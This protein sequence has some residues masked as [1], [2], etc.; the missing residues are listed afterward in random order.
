MIVLSAFD[1]MSC[2]QIALKELGYKPKKY[3][4]SEIDKFAIKQTQYNFQNTIQLG[5]ITKIKADKL[6]KIDLF[7]GGSPCKGFSFA[8]K[9]LNF[10]DPESKLFFEFIRLLDEIKKINPNAKYLLENVNMKRKYLG[11]ISKKLG[12]FP[13]RINSNLV[14]AQNRD[15]FYWTNIKTK[16]DGIFNDLYSDIPLPNNQNIFYNQKMKLIK[17]IMYHKKLLIE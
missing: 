2:G 17:N 8:G 6:D 3:Y 15:R 5:D 13:V 14:S 9:Q 11:I 12:V 1:G 7:L 10:K 4:S 16:S